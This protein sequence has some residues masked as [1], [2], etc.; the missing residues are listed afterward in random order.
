VGYSLANPI[1]QLG[2]LTILNLGFEVFALLPFDGSQAQ[3]GFSVGTEARPFGIIVQP[4]YYGGGFIRLLTNACDV[5]RFEIQLEFGAATAI[6]FGPLSGQGRVTSGFYLDVMKGGRSAFKGF[7]HAI[8]EGQ[9][10]CFGI[11]VN[12][13]V[14]VEH[15]D[16]AMTGKSSY[17]F[18]FKVGFIEFSYR[19]TATYAFHKEQKK[20]TASFTDCPKHETYDFVL[21]AA[22]KQV[23][24]DDYRAHFVKEWK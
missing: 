4:C 12:L 21:A 10:A 5:I 7:V 22:D 2:A 11:C 23:N 14:A 19:V 20:L 15:R 8:G 24:W 18:S 16:G 13:E 1:V 17:Q 9:V 6:Q 3:L